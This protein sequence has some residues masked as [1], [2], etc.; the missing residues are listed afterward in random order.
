MKKKRER[1]GTF[2]AFV[3]GKSSDSQVM[4]LKDKFKFVNVLYSIEYEE[5]DGPH[6]KR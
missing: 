6:K 3:N 2:S 1:S 4:V 5:G